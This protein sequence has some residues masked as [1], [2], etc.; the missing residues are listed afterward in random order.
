ME[1][2]FTIL[3]GMGTL[4]TQAFVEVLN[5]NTPAHSDQEFLNYVVLNHAT[6]PD[7]TA[8]L[9]D[10]TKENPIPVLVKDIQSMDQLGTDFFVLTC[11]TAHAFFEELQKATDKEILHMPREAVREIAKSYPQASG[12]KVGFLGTE[13]SVKAGVYAREIMQAGYQYVKPSQGLQEK[14]NYLI[15]HEVKEHSRMNFE[16]YFE[17][18][19]ELQEEAGLDLIILGCTELSLIEEKAPRH[20][21]NVIDAQSVVAQRAIE[22]ALFNRG[23]ASH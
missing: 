4:A 12:T 16:L 1:N 6:V 2:F 21:Y 15:Y 11:N 10:Q 9:L 19:A 5:K 17:I 22:K 23:K 20:T 13:G 18:L 8:Y 3:G 7:R 14:V